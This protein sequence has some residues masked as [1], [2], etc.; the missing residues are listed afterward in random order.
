MK[1]IPL[2]HHVFVLPDHVPEIIK[3]GNIFTVQ[4]DSRKMAI[5][6]KI[7]SIGQGWIRE[8]IA[9]DKPFIGKLRPLI[10]RPGMRV[11]FTEFAGL[12]IPAIIGGKPVFI[13]QMREDEITAVIDPDDDMM[14][15]LAEMVDDDEYYSV[16]SNAVYEIDDI[17]GTSAPGSPE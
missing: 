15:K 13:K 3:I 1:L 6:G 8:H 2:Y 14:E 10:L 9:R 11:L 12:V 17:M 16:M 5:T 7:I 4:N